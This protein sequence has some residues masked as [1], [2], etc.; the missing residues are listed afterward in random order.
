MTIGKKQ[1][2]GVD[3][4]GSVVYNRG[5]IESNYEEVGRSSTWDAKVLTGD[6]RTKYEFDNGYVVSLLWGERSYGTQNEFGQATS[7][8][9]AVFT[10]DEGKGHGH[11]FLR[12]T[13]FDDV[14]GH[15]SWDTVEFILN[16]INEGNA[17]DLE[18]TY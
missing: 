4:W 2:K 12:L 9:I 5:M 8:E 15:R 11:Q 1:H 18:L 3:A 16:K 17:T 14:I 10:P 7:Y 6:K 13:E